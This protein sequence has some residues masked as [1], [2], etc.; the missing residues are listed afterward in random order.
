MG[1]L[2]GGSK[3]PCEVAL[4]V[5]KIKASTIIWGALFAVKY[6]SF[7]IILN[8]FRPS[9][10]AIYHLWFENCGVYGPFPACLIIGFLKPVNSHVRETSLWNSWIL[11]FGE[12]NNIAT[13]ENNTSLRHHG[14]SSDEVT[15]SKAHSPSFTSRMT[16]DP[17]P[18]SKFRGSVMC[19][20][21]LPPLWKFIED[22]SFNQKQIFFRHFD[23]NYT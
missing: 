14:F 18:F 15:T 21:V 22:S 3:P 2:F 23:Q 5:L 7:V 11:D 16:F 4:R 6:I 17:F 10:N 1:I 20:R 9:T 8:I 13:A 12:Q 19:F